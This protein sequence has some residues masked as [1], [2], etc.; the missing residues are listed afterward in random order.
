MATKDD[1]K[2]VM[3]RADEVDDI[4]VTLQRLYALDDAIFNQTQLNRPAGYIVPLH[5]IRKELSDKLTTL[6]S[7]SKTTEE[8]VKSA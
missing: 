3:Y 6:T 8:P 1:K 4:V 2:D 5:N 7:K